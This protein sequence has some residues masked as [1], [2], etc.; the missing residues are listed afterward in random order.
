MATFSVYDWNK[1]EVGKVEFPDAL[2]AKPFKPTLLHEVVRMQLANRRSGTA[3]TKTKGEVS[4]GGKKPW[5]QKGTGRARQGSTRSPLWPGGGTVFGPR[6]R[7]YS[8]LMTK[9]ARKQGLGNAVAERFRENKVL[10]LDSLEWKD[11]STKKA[12]AAFSK[13]GVDNALV[14]ID[15]KDEKFE[16][17]VRNLQNFKVIRSEGLNVLDVVSYDWL[18]MTQLAL[19]KVQERVS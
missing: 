15:A 2:L 1:K 19:K 10:V 14:V 9:K 8:F 7:D 17:S 12:A 3:S 16:R 5:R 13:L 18:L 6:P 4:G 11:Y